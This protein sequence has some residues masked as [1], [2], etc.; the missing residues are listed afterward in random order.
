MQKI[1]LA[2]NLK[3]SPIVHGHYRLNDWKI[4][5]QDL[6]KLTQQAIEYGI[7]TFDHADIYGDYS[8]EKLFGDTLVNKKGIRNDIQI[9]TKCGIKPVSDKF[10][11]RKT[12][13]YDY[14]SNYIIS[15]VNQSLSNLRTDYI[16]LLMLHRPS[17]FFAAEEVAIAFSYLKKSGKVL[18]FGVSNFDPNQYEMLD[19]FLEDKLVTNQIEISPYCLENFKN[20]NLDFLLKKKL[21]P[22]AW[23]PLAGGEI[24]FP[25]TE[26]GQGLLKCITEI[27]R[28]LGEESI[29][30]IIY[31]WLLMHPSGI[32][33]VVGTS[34]SL[35]LKNAIDAFDIN[36]SLEQWFKIY[37]TSQGT[38]MP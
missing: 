8:C 16:D 33:P 2:Q 22:M 38:E 24:L 14:S 12:K 23:S 15:S 37:I 5:K 17:P 25:K 3:I 13:Y 1:E 26:K 20:G 31:K 32:I 28:E 21:R 10:P 9:I 34:K 19:S 35:R 7:T 6:L 11:E 18:Q 4:S 27:A 36:L 29:D 30:K